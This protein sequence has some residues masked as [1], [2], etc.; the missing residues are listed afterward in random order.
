MLFGKGGRN[1]I[2]D[3]NRKFLFRRTLGQDSELGNERES[4]VFLGKV[5][6]F[7]EDVLNRTFSFP[8]FG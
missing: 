4:D 5:S 2:N 8:L 6:E 1:N 3:I 7:F